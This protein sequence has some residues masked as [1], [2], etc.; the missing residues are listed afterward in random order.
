M[1]RLARLRPHYLL[2]ANFV[3]IFKAPLLAVPAVATV[4]FH[5]SPLPRYAGLAPFF[6][7]AKH[8]ERQGGVSAVI[9]DEAIDAGPVLGQR[10]IALS[11]TESAGEIRAL[12]FQESFRLVRE[13]LPMLISRRLDGKPQ[14]LRRRS[15]FGGPAEEDCTIDWTAGAEAVLRTVRAAHPRPG[16]RAQ[17]A[18][19][20]R[21]CV[22]AAPR[23]PTR[24]HGH[25]PGAGPCRP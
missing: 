9:T 19:G 4:N 15:Y 7:M 20:E 24:R 11:G 10:P 8:G 23:R 18:D 13:M 12:H 5:P 25:G 3:Q 17:T 14:D 16:A 21:L 6:W 22:L 1:A 2:I